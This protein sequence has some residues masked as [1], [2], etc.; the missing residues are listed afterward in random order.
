MAHTSIKTSSTERE[1]S[2]CGGNNAIH[3]ICAHLLEPIYTPC[4]VPT[5]LSRTIHFDDV[6]EVNSPG[7]VSSFH[8]HDITQNR[9]TAVK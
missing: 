3:L 1:A 7:K 2:T 6:T 5:R 4:I 9:L 8:S